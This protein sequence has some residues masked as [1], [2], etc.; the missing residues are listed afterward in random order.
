MPVVVI[1]EST[2]SFMKLLDQCESQE[3]EAPGGITPPPVYRNIKSVNS[4]PGGM[5]SVGQRIW[6]RDFLGIC[7]TI[8]AHQWSKTIQPIM[9]ALRDVTRRCAFDFAAFV[10]L[11]VEQ[12]VKDILEQGW[13]TNSSTRMVFPRKLV[14]GVLDISFNRF[15][16]LSEPTPVLP[17]PNEQ[18]LARLTDYVAFLKN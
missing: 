5:W 4:E 13:Q 11:P 3:L 1:A 7:M 17:I 6:Q 2:F 14:T 16:P 9:G 10:G 15:I 18:Q 12:A 8:N